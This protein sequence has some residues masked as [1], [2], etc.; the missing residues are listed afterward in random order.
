MRNLVSRM[1]KIF[2]QL[3]VKTNTWKMCKEFSEE[4]IQIVNKH[5]KRHPTSLLIKETQKKVTLNP[6]RMSTIKKTKGNN[7]W[8]GWR[9]IGTLLHCWRACK[10]VCLLWKTF[11][12]VFTMLNTELLYDPAILFLGICIQEN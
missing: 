10:M 1:C 3:N 4:Y 9:G 7:Y 6:A 5:M 12:H 11:W 2:L 8:Q